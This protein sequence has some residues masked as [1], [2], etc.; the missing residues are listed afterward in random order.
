MNSEVDLLGSYLS[1]EYNVATILSA[2]FDFF[3][4]SMNFK[5]CYLSCKISKRRKFG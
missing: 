5:H 4:V 3:Y 1:K 2:R